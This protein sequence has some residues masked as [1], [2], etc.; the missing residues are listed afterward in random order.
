MYITEG[1]KAMT[2]EMDTALL[3][4]LNKNPLVNFAA[5]YEKV[6]RDKLFKREVTIS[7]DTRVY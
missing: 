2:K 4:E 7:D 3:R 5:L 1:L 6:E